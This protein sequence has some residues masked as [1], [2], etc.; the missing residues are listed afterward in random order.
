MA[1]IQAGLLRPCQLSAIRLPPGL[2]S[3]A[4]E[5]QDCCCMGPKWQRRAW[6]ADIAIVAQGRGLPVHS[7]TL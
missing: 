3:P 6:R 4:M 2:W 5:S 7:T 1:C